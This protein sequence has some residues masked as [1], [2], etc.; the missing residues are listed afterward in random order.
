V[1]FKLDGGIEHVLIDEAQD[2]APD[3]WDIFKALTEE[4]FV[5]GAERREPPKDDTPARTSSRSAT[6]SS[7]SIPS[8]AP[9]PN[10]CGIEAQAYDS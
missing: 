6:R 10:G 3:Q 9:G 2:T 1:L 7:R 4:F 5:G 8:R